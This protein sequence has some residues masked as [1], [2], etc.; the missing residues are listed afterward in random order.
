MCTN[1]CINK[2]R[3]DTPCS[4]YLPSFLWWIHIS[5]TKRAIEERHQVQVMLCQDQTRARLGTKFTGNTGYSGKPLCP[6]IVTSCHKHHRGQVP[7]GATAHRG[8]GDR[9]APDC[10]VRYGVPE[11]RQDRASRKRSTSIR[12]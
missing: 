4:S 2:I 7:T 3:K 12:K 10:C 5:K 1:P 11:V 8:S 6:P 9:V